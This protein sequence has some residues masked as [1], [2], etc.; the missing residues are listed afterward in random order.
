MAYYQAA[1][2]D[3]NQAVIVAELRQLGYDV[4]VVSHAHRRGGGGYDLVVSAHGYGLRV[5]VKRPGEGLNDNE[6][7]YWDEQRHPE[8]L[9]IARCAEDILNWFSER[10]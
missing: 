8:N 9:I 2:V 7:T 3:M 1:K 4:D 10:V 5:E 6:Q